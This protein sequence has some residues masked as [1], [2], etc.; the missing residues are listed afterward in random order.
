MSE[1]PP[2]AD[3]G[4]DMPGNM[5]DNPPALEQQTQNPLATPAVAFLLINPN[6]NHEEEMSKTHTAMLE[7]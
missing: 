3:H 5:T 7:L 2:P 4:V 1:Q 6:K